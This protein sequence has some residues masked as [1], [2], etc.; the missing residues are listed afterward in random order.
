MPYYEEQQARTRRLLAR[1]SRSLASSARV[2]RIIA[3]LTILACLPV[4]VVIADTSPPLALGV[5]V[6]GAAQSLLM[7]AMGTGLSGM[8]AICDHLSQRD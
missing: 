6:S 8:A 5:G 3:V 2:V 1:R 4:C 7:F